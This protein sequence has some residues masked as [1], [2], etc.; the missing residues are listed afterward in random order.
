MANTKY[1]SRIPLA[2]RKLAYE[3]VAEL[4]L[5]LHNLN[6]DLVSVIV[7]KDS[8]EVT[9]TKAIPVDQLEHLGLEE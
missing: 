4:F 6:L 1:K 9:L 3:R 2:S 5:H 8:I 7:T